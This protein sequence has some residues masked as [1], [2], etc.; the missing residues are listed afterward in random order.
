MRE[1]ITDA[2]DYAFVLG[3]LTL[4]IVEQF[5]SGGTSVLLGYS[6][7]LAYGTYLAVR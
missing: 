3:V 7:G 1:V 4:L 2:L 5:I 6:F